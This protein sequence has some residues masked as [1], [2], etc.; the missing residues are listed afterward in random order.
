VAVE[1]GCA[2][3]ESGTA[4]AGMGIGIADYDHD[5]R[6]DLF[7]TNF[8]NQP[9]TLYRNMG[10]GRFQDVSMETGVALPHMQFLSFGC[11]FF[12]YDA[13]GWPDLI[14]A[15]GHVQLH[16]DSASPGVTYSERKQ[17]FHNEGGQ[18]FAEVTTGLGDL[19]RP[20]VSRGLAVG[21]VDNSGRLDILVNNQNGPAQLFMN[22]SPHGHWI[23][24]AT[25]GTKSNREG[26]HAR[27]TLTA[28]GM[29]QTAEVRSG[30]SYASASDRRVYFGLGAATRVESLEVRWPS[31]IHD[32]ARDLA[33]D[34]FYTITE[35]RGVAPIGK[36]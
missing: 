28:G 36:R 14:V 32:S 11:E 1:A 8:S 15:N 5:G 7:V 27:L 12:D 2:F 13:D 6:E 30:S 21:D 20:M 23:S 4:L 29:R 9:N 35:G 22:D 16:A 26:R 31:G 34:T 33:V 3:A 19:A 18:R 24:F 25:T 17:L 10:Q